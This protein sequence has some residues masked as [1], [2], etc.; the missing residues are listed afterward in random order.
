MTVKSNNLKYYGMNGEISNKCGDKDDVETDTD[1][2]DGT[3]CGWFHIRPTWLQYFNTASWLAATLGVLMFVQGLAINGFVYINISTI[4]TRYN[5]SSTATGV[6]VS[7]YDVTVSVLIVFVSY[8]GATRNKPLILGS[9]AVIMG[10]GSLVWALPQFTTGLYEYDSGHE[11]DGLCHLDGNSTDATDCTKEQETLS[12]YFFVFVFAQILYGIGASPIYTVGYAYI[13]E[14]TTHAK[15]AWYMALLSACSVFGPTT[16]FLLGAVFLTIY[17]DV[18]YQDSVTITSSDPSWVGAW[19][20][21]FLIA[22]VLA[23]LIA[24]P[25][26]AFPPELPGARAFQH[27]RGSEAHYNEDSELL[28]TRADFGRGWKDLWPATKMLFK[29]PFY[30]FTTISKCAMA[31]VVG[32]LLPFITKFIENQFGLTSSEAALVLA[33]TALPGAAG[34]TLFGGWFV[35]KARL[36]VRGIGIQ[37]FLVTAIAICLVPVFLLQCPQQS[38]AGVTASYNVSD[39]SPVTEVNIENACNIDCGCHGTETYDPICGENDM[40]YFDSCHAGC[41][42]TSDDGEVYYNCTCIDTGDGS[43]S[44]QA[45]SGTCSVYC[46]QLLAFALGFFVILFLGFSLYAPMSLLALRCVPYQQRAHALGISSILYRCLGSVPGPIVFGAVIDSSCLVWQEQCGKTGS[47][48]IYDNHMFAVK[49]VVLSAIGCGI[50]SLAYAL[51][52]CTYRPPPD[53]EIE[54]ETETEDDSRC[55]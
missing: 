32:G 23:W 31:F 21:G 27:E 40:V 13:D 33:V 4:E 17:V 10:L 46:W 36:T 37:C 35:K 16:G 11:G 53:T 55:E 51:A 7:S 34:G 28:K 5:L 45:V 52:V 41:M 50:A 6:I 30:V 19:W 29:N 54:T 15:S 48:W 44:S 49:I 25:M 3:L 18:G 47:C 22:W 12:Y 14:N 20:I 26:A 8:F 1:N 42:D 43:S 9:G 2:A 24:P 38:I 39:S